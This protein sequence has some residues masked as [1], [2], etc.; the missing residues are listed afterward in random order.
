V[1]LISSPVH[2]DVPAL[3]TAYHRRI[4]QARRSR[5]WAGLALAVGLWWLALAVAYYFDQIAAVLPL[6]LAGTA[7]LVI[8]AAWLDLRRRSSLADTARLLG[9][10][11]DNRQRLTT[12]V[13]LLDERAAG[14]VAQAQLATSAALLGRAD[15]G[16]VVPVR[17]P[18]PLVVVSLGLLLLALGLFV[19]KQAPGAA[20][21]P[22]NL[23]ADQQGVGA[24]PT[25]TPD[26][27]LPGANPTPPAGNPSGTASDGTEPQ[28]LGPGTDPVTAAQQLASKEAK[29]ALDRLAAALGEQSVTQ[30]AGDSLRQGQYDQAATQLTDVG[31]QNDQLS[32]EA[33]QGL[34]DA[35][36]RAAQ[37]TPSPPE[38]QKAEQAAAAALQSGHYGRISDA[39]KA[40]GDAVHQAGERVITQPDLAKSY[41]DQSGQAGTGPGGTP[42]SSASGAPPPQDAAGTQPG[43][44]G[45]GTQA[46]DSGN[47]SGQG[48]SAGG[49]QGG[50]GDQSGSGQGQGDAQGNGSGQ[51]DS[52]A[53]NGAAGTGTPGGGN[54]NGTGTG[55]AAGEGSRVSGPEETAPLDV[56]GT[57]FE[58]E[59][60]PDPNRP[61]PPDPNEPP[62]LTVDGD[63]GNSTTTTPLAP[64]SPGSA[65]SESNQ[66]PVERWEP[67]QRYFG[68][69]GQ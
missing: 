40:L 23:P 47:Q 28:Q 38:L 67:V 34:A 62:G 6:G 16:A 41:P 46:G 58:L 54:G 63:G 32:T 43:P 53:Q 9:A 19:L 14:P 5:V 44:D 48:D 69:D 64:G 15:P 18:W 7:G 55:G 31:K 33:K 52:S 13:E 56:A 35:L 50:S 65:P 36:N 39:M 61:G 25:P 26:A 42:D 49:D 51:G 27:G 68:H 10:R 57:P 8:G 66:L 12:S 29:E 2:A 1:A 37:D 59:S 4:R 20:W 24:L 3:L 11:L 17:S 22:G 45:Q 21:L 60:Q 30:A